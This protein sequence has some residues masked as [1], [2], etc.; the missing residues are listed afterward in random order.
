MDNGISR[1]GGLKAVA[2]R[3]VHFGPILALLS[4]RR[5]AIVL[6]LGVVVRVAQY[7]GNRRLWFDE[8]GLERNLVVKSFGGLFG[9]LLNDQFAPPGFLV[10]E[11][12]MD[13]ILGVDR[14]A[15]RLVPLAGGIASLFLFERLARRCLR[16]GAVW[17]AVGLFAVSDDLIYF[18]SELKQYST[19]VTVALL[20][21]LF[22]SPVR[23]RPPTVS[24][25]AAFAALGMVAPW[26]SH[27]SVFVLAGLGTCEVASALRRREWR[28][29]IAISLVGALWFAS[30][31]GLYVVSLNQ[32]GHR[33]AMWVFWNFAFPPL[34]PSSFR[35]AIWPI[36]R[37][38]YLFFNPWEFRTPLGPRLSVLLA[39]GLFLAG[40]GSLWKRGEKGALW[41][42]SSPGPFALLASY[43]RLYPFHGRL[44]LFLVPTLV[45]L[46][47]ERLEWVGETVGKGTLWAILIGSIFVLPI[48]AAVENAFV[49]RQRIDTNDYGDR[50]PLKLDPARFPF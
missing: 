38:A 30:C 50:R 1:R 16:P 27:P 6:G 42:L 23:G 17:I 28:T 48:W 9:P 34:P 11:W 45:L 32:L 39:S 46:V 20:C 25:F 41:M 26:F 33:R 7:L 15:E 29:A 8:S 4:R 18:A 37:C 24:R 5:I 31:A 12:G 21:L 40:G 49:P 14:L 3:E 36:R 2:G 10:V 22:G 19:D 44:L 43:L 47:A 35:E 13:R